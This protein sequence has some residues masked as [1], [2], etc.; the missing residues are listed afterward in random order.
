MVLDPEVS[1][2]GVLTQTFLICGVAHATLQ[3]LQLANDWD[4]SKLRAH[5][6]KAWR[7]IASL[8]GRNLA[9]AR[10]EPGFDC[11]CLRASAANDDAVLPARFSLL[12]D[13]ASIFLDPKEPHVYKSI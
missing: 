6:I 2:A 5:R 1:F 7:V 12:V 11:H 3:H 4:D 8:C 13:G 10:E 9:I